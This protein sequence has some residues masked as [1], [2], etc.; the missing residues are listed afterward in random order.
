MELVH[1]REHNRLGGN[2]RRGSSIALALC[3]LTM[4]AS[5]ATAQD[6]MLPPEI[7]FQVPA[8]AKTW[9]VAS[10]LAMPDPVQLNNVK[11]DPTVRALAMQLE[12]ASFEVR[13]QATNKLIEMAPDKMQL[14]ALLAPESDLTAEQRYRLLAALREH[15]LN[16]PRGAVGISM[17]PVQPI[18]MGGPLEIR[19]T[20]LLPGLPAER[21]LKLND[22]ITHV[23]D[24]PL[25]AYDDLQFRVQ[26]KRPGDKVALTI[27]RPKTDPAV[28]NAGREAN[29]PIPFEVIRVELELGS[30]EL[31]REFN[32]ARAQ[33]FNQALPQLPQRVETIR[34][35][36]VQ[37]ASQNFS[38]KPRSIAITGS[39]A[40]LASDAHAATAELDPDVE[41]HPTV[42]E[43]LRHRKLIET[44]DVTVEELQIIRDRWERELEELSRQAQ[45]R[46]LT[47]DQRAYLNAVIY[48]CMQ[49]MQ[50]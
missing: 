37:R 24:Q 41:N 46:M 45:N 32:E 18:I 19:V 35:T 39:S 22:R 4:F 30:A 15:L 9:S 14:Y 13:E 17:E 49:L 44:G 8:N 5:V 25:F 2:S 16:S 7:I 27:K 42:Q 21:V 34:L 47:S 48:R 11:I 23:D 1:S 33:Q 38:P 40:I 10:A 3:A 28:L 20:D 31:L 26:C 43:V 29:Q 12:D 6:E 36:E 50:F